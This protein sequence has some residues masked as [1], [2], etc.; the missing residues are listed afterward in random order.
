MRHGVWLI[1]GPDHPDLPQAARLAPALSTPPEGS[2]PQR[3]CRPLSRRAAAR[4][5]QRSVGVDPGCRSAAGDR[6][7]AVA[8]GATMVQGVI[9]AGLLDKL[10]LHVAPVLLNGGIRLLDSIHPKTMEL[11]LGR[12]VSSADV[13]HLTYRFKKGAGREAS[14][15]G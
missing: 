1:Q 12:V 8:D 13:L 14:R 2:G 5:R 6:D 11:E 9:A 10:S 7:V 3:M 4:R 15:L